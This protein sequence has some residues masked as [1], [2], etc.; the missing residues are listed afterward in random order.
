MEAWGPVGSTP[1]MI[2][3]GM[4]RESSAKRRVQIWPISDRMS[5]IDELRSLRIW[6]GAALFF[7]VG[8]GVAD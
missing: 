6:A 1:E 3:A 8:L 7:G 4:R 5:G 2:A